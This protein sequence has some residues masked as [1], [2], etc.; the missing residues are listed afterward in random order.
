MHGKKIVLGNET[1]KVNFTDYSETG[2]FAR[3][4]P[5]ACYSNE[6]IPW[7]A[8]NDAITCLPSAGMP[9]YQ[10]GFSTMLSAVVVILQCVWAVTMYVIWIDAEINSPLVRSGYR[11]TQIRA[12]FALSARAQDTLDAPL[13][14]LIAVPVDKVTKSLFQK[15][16][17][18]DIE[19]F[20]KDSTPA[21]NSARE[22]EETR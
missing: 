2:G 20:T 6:T 19:L 10:W 17:T 14:E 8:V 18:V 7:S 13:D 1:L 22:E 21:K 16:S 11:M 3:G 9:L 12:A 4:L 15:G 5:Y